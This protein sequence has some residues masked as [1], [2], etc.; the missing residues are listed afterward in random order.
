MDILNERDDEWERRD[1]DNMPLET[2]E[3][4]GGDALCQVRALLDDPR[5]PLNEET[6]KRLVR[7][8][9]NYLAWACRRHDQH[10]QLARQLDT[11]AHEVAERAKVKIPPV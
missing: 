6:G 9:K 7:R 8:L 11:A 3:A 1:W 5:H 10:L 2:V 4:L